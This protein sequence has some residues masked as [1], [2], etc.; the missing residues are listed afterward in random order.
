MTNVKKYIE[1]NL[2]KTIREVREDFGTYIG[3]PYPFTVPSLKDTFQEM[4][5]WDTYFINVGLL[6]NGNIQQAKNNC[7]NFRYLIE[8]Y[9]FIPNGSRTFFLSR[10]QP[11]YYAF[12]VNDLEKYLSEDEKRS[13]YTSI[14]CEYKWWH[15]N[16]RS[17]IG[18]NVYGDNDVADD[19]CC[20]VGKDACL[21]MGEIFCGEMCDI[22]RNF[23]AIAESG[24]DCS[25]RFDTYKGR[26]G[27]IESFPIDLNCNLYFYETYL[28]SLQ[29]R[30]NIVDGEDWAKKA[31][32][33]KILIDRYMWD[34]ENC[35]YLDYNFVT[36]K[37]C[38]VISCA[39]FQPY[40][41]GMAD[42]DKKQGL[43]NAYN[44]LMCDY[45]IVAA[46]KKDNGNYQW[47]YPNGWA[48]LH[49][50]A[51]IALKNYGFDAEAKN[52]AEKY[53]SLVDSIFTKTGSLWEKYNVVNGSL[54][55]ASE[56]GTPEMLGWTAGVYLYFYN[57]LNEN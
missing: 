23:I 33:R 41:T 44:R 20:D 57:A 14:K 52:I 47:A 36:Q 32:D 35:I 19:V 37:R 27:C 8:K 48:N 7:F 1:E 16:R 40:F 43:I 30:L 5:Y 15:D 54:N 21:R 39:A 2:S 26:L 3:L 18:L 45:G 56:Y 22:G 31:K 11:P 24:W 51:Y 50:I 12:I 38:D 25:P 17:E 55:V 28:D 53:L 34:D 10:S 4:Y 29:K 49:Y 6:A 46:D 9:G 13:L 42:V